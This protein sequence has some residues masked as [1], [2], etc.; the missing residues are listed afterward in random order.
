MRRFSEWHTEKSC[1]QGHADD[2]H[3]VKESG[4][5]RFAHGQQG[6]WRRRDRAD[7]PGEI[8]DIQSRCAAVAIAFGDPEIGAR[9]GETVSEAVEPTGQQS[10]REGGGVEQGEADSQHGQAEDDGGFEAFGGNERAG[11]ENSHE[12]GGKLYEREKSGA[13]VVESPLG[14]E[15]RKNRSNEGDD[16]AVDDEAAAEQREN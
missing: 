6:Q 5:L 1:G 15:Y 10:E 9:S 11:R 16:D 4:D 12:R 14:H 8:C 7:A 13:A 2:G 3:H